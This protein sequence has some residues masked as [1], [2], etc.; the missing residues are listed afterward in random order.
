MQLFSRRAAASFVML[1]LFTVMLIT[2]L[3]WGGFAKVLAYGIVICLDC[4]GL[5]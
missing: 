2:G 3:V 5:I 4:I 1:A